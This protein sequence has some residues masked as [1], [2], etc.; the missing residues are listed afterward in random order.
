MAEDTVHLRYNCDLISYQARIL[1]D[2]PYIMHEDRV[3]SFSNYDRYTCR[4]ANG[5]LAQG[6]RSGEGLAILMGNCPEYL[7]L[8]YG[9]PRAGL[10]SVPV[11]V[12][13]KGDG[14]KYILENSDVKYLVADDVLYPKVAEIGPKIGGIKKIFIRRTTDMSLPDN[15]IDLE[16]LLD[17]N[18]E[19]PDHVLDPNA[20][21]YLMYTSGTTG[22][23]KGVANRNG[24]G[25]IEGMISL[26]RQ[27]TQP[28]DVLYTALPLFHANALVLTSSWAMGAGLSFG[29]DNK[30][31]ASRFWERTKFYGATQ[32]NGLGA[33][34]P[35]LMKQP[36]KADDRD[37]P[38]RK[39]I[40][41]AC[42][43]NLWKAFEKRFNLKI[44]EA[45]GAVD[46]GGLLIVNMGDAPVGSIGKIRGEIEWKL[47]D[48]QGNK[49]PKGDIGELVTRNQER[50]S[51]GVEYYKN[52]EESRKK[53]QGGWI[54]SGDYFYADKDGNLFFAD[55]KTDSMRRRGENISSFEVESIVEKHPEVAVCAAFGVPSELGEDEVMIWVIPKKGVE[56]DLKD[57]ICY[58]ADNMAYF[59]VPRYIDIVEEIP[60]TG[61]LR[62]VKTDMKQQG[63]TARTWDREKEMPDLKLK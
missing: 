57:L 50:K 35:I 60:R 58:C 14:L 18:D 36:E 41:A 11:N 29:L 49:V 34:I 55:R 2:K 22:F 7:F 4:A 6:A 32:F 51:S 13:L 52:P 62:I 19:K 45:Y 43:A 8:F 48:D 37:N 46:G 42:P 31:S 27:M 25:R 10:Y 40:S 56:L 24:L 28:D 21:T 63:V 44:W 33:M 16:D 1:G 26:A 53:T 61:T 38:V 17:A 15:A 12:A 39:V 23:P 5:M 54:Y 30:F 20:I 47:I 3:V 9:L 59:M